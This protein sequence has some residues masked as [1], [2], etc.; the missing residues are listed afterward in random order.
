M[1]KSGARNDRRK[2]I[3]RRCGEEQDVP[4]FVAMKLLTDV[5]RDRVVR[6][7]AEVIDFGGPRRIIVSAGRDIASRVCLL[8]S[9]A[10]SRSRVLVDVGGLLGRNKRVV[11]NLW[12]VGRSL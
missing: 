5:F 6:S 9:V 7:I 3:K 8:V 10:G 11:V 2:N 12:C 4:L 1:A